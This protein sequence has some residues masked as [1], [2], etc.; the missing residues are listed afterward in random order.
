VL[1]EAGSP[2]V[3]LGGDND[4]DD[5]AQLVDGAVHVAPPASDLC[6]GLIH[7]PAVP[8]GVP[9]GQGGLGE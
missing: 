3:T 4:I 9:A 8:D 5:L 1:E 6:V 2:P 7:L